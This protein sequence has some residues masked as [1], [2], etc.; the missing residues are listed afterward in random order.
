MSGIDGHFFK[1][2]DVYKMS[3]A[4]GAALSVNRLLFA[5]D[6]N[7]PERRALSAQGQLHF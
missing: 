6:T 3:Q 4:T 1:P 7:A 2:L 5:S